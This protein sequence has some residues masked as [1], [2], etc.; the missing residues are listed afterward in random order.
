MEARDLFEASSK[1]NTF[2]RVAFV[3]RCQETVMVAGTVNP[4]W[5]QTLIFEDVLITGSPAQIEAYPPIV[6]IEVFADREGLEPEFLGRCFCKVDEVITVNKIRNK[7]IDNAHLKWHP[8]E[9]S[10]GKFQ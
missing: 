5:Q 7:D 2:A 6:A 10:P 4:I 3:N 8:L 9:Y 1:N